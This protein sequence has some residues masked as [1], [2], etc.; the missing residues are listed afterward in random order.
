VYD[1]P[2]FVLLMG[3]V[4]T[5]SCPPYSQY[6]CHTGI[7]VY[8]T[9]FFCFPQCEVPFVPSPSASLPIHLRLFVS[10]SC[11]TFLTGAL[12][13]LPPGL[14]LGIHYVLFLSFLVTAQPCLW[15]P[16]RYYFIFISFPFLGDAGSL[17]L[18]CLLI[19]CF[20]RRFFVYRRPSRR[21]P[22]VIFVSAMSDAL[23]S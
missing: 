8:P 17:F 1:A 16:C 23:F 20:A 18:R 4:P 9:L 14:P 22:L 6:F 21:I 3:L 5:L 10:C 12:S 13:S 11:S 19:R 15:S 7:P 2:S